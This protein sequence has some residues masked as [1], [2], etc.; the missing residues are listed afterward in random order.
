MRCYCGVLL[1]FGAVWHRATDC[2]DCVYHPV[3]MP[4]CVTCSTVH[5]IY[6][7]LKIQP[8]AKDG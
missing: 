3:V 6:E 2:H 5:A 1:T 7:Y 8:E 4:R